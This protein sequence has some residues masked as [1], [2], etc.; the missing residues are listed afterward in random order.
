[1][2][3]GHKILT[4]KKTSHRQPLYNY[5]QTGPWVLFLQCAVHA[6]FMGSNLVTLEISHS[7][8]LGIRSHVT[9]E[10]E[11]PESRTEDS[12]LP[13]SHVLGYLSISSYLFYLKKNK[14]WWQLPWISK[15]GC[16]LSLVCFIGCA[17]HIP[18]IHLWCNTCWPLGNQH[19]GRA[20][21]I[22]ILANKHWFGL[23][24]Y[25]LHFETFLFIAIIK[26]QLLS[27]LHIFLRL[28]F[29]KWSIDS[30][31]S[32]GLTPPDQNF[33][34]FLQFL[35]NCVCWRL[36]PGGLAPSPKGNAGSVPDRK[37]FC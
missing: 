33:L 36:P 5:L 15:S 12:G 10:K 20:V 23:S 24:Y 3:F 17:W 35:G 26:L 25:L 7:A 27:P 29:E 9:N 1:M 37:D 2:Y 22:N 11:S 8:I 14:T 30:G 13:F 18:Q 31:G 19:G 21:S 6:G 32:K 4:F 28:G 34:N 16:I